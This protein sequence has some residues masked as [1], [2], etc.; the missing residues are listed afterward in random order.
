MPKPPIDAEKI[1]VFTGAGISASS[2]IQTFRDG[3]GLWHQYRIEDVATPE[4]WE[5][6][7]ELVLQFYNERRARAAE[8]QPNAGHRAIADL[9]RRFKVTV[10]TQNVDDLHERAGSSEVIHLHGELRKA[11]STSDPVFLYDLGA[12]PILLGD[13]CVRGSQLR[14]HIVWFGEEI[15]NYAESREHLMTASRVIVVGTSLAVYPAAGLLQ[16]ARHAARKLIV[17]LEA[18]ERPHGYQFMAGSADVVLPQLVA[19]WMKGL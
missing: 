12:R 9:E 11:R 10:V 16:H 8:A 14:P 7:P 4:A 18:V 2:G 13:C 1:V 5:R 3:G 19:D 6:R 17:N 15:M